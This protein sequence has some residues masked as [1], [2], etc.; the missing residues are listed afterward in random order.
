MT[1]PADDLADEFA[2]WWLSTTKTGQPV[3][4]VLVDPVRGHI[5]VKGDRPEAVTFTNLGPVLDLWP[6][7]GGASLTPQLAVELGEALVAWSRSRLD[8][9]TV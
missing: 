8:S 1:T 7:N 4:R 2:A 9:D 6:G 5:A 3:D